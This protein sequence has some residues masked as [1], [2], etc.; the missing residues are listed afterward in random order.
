MPGAAAPAAGSGT[1]S[2][3]AFA[4]LQARLTALATDD[5]PACA[6]EGTVVAI[7]SINLDQAVLDRHADELAALEERCLYLLFA[8]RR[9]RIRVIAVTSLPIREDVLEYYLRLLPEA[10]EARA[11]IDLLSPDD[12]SARPL[13]QKILE[14]PELL[15]RVAELVPDRAR[16]FIVPF[17]V[18]DCERDLALELDIPIYGI[19]HRF[20]R[21]GTKSGSRRLFA[22]AGVSHPLG[23]NALRSSAGLAD[24]L[25]SLRHA[26]PGLEGAV[27]KHDDAVSGDG[28]RIITLRDLPPRGTAEEAAA[29]DVRLRSL[30]SSYLEK[31]GDGGVVEELIAG[32]VGSPSVQIRI[33]PGGRPRVVSTHDQVLGGELNQTFVACRFPARRDYASAI[34]REARKAGEYL[35][36]RGVAGRFGIDFVVARRNGA[37]APYAVDINLREGGTSHPFETLW[38][39]T[40]GSLDETETTYRTPSGQAK[41]YFATDRL[42]HPSDRRIALGDFLA[43]TTAA[44]LVWDPDSE[45]GAVFH[46]LRSLEEEGRIGVTAIGDSPEQAH[47]L[48]LG[49]ARLL[50]RLAATASRRQA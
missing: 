19:D 13:A 24:A 8:L 47:E 25:V 31:L 12:D 14:R 22:S 49:V 6:A 15:A 40:D 36:A 50:D 17:N 7:P 11:R 44:G 41:H 45:T 16:C 3:T 27:V 23:A 26:R 4:R 37:W 9:A 35:A 43:A 1:D 30:G 42:S 5:V 46:L 20:A 10:E 38:L 21:Y 39:L 33:V 29:L 48:Y 18:R 32:E 28:N 34:V 2:E